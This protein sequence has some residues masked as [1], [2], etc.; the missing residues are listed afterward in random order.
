MIRVVFIPDPDPDFLPIPDPGDQKSTGSRIRI[1]NTLPFT[2][3]KYKIF[4]SPFADSILAEP[5][6]DCRRLQ[7]P[8]PRHP[9]GQGLRLRRG[10]QR[11]PRPRLPLR[12]HLCAAAAERAG[13]VCGKESVGALGWQARHGVDGG[14]AGVQLGRGR[15]REAGPLFA[16]PL[17]QAACHRGECSKKRLKGQ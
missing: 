13:P 11:P 14:R 8:L 4:L 16:P 17:R 7:V 2:H 6:V 10:N 15:G 5:C 1:R 9:R 3:L 12:Q